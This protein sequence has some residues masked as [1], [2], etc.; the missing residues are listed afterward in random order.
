MLRL[1]F[2]DDLLTGHDEVDRQHRL[3]FDAT[4]SPGF[5]LE[6]HLAPETLI[7]APGIPLG[8]SPGALRAAGPRVVHDPLQIGTA[9]M[10][11]EALKP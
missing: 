11:A 9:V 7:A 1:E 4:P 5:I 10:L 6:R 8:L 2:P 3:L